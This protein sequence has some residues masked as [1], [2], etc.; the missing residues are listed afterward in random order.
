MDVPRNP[1]FLTKFT[2]QI[3][4]KINLGNERFYSNYNKKKPPSIPRRCGLFSLAAWAPSVPTGSSRWPTTVAILVPADHRP[5]HRRYLRRPVPPLGR[6]LFSLAASTTRRRPKLFS[7]AERDR[8]LR[9]RRHTR[10]AHLLATFGFLFTLAW[11]TCLK[12]SDNLYRRIRDSTA[13][14]VSR[15]RVFRVVERSVLWWLDSCLRDYREEKTI[16]FSRH[17]PGRPWLGRPGSR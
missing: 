9:Y 3:V 15:L 17:S 10:Q 12:P 8:T 6:A 14:A 13:V 7:L 11:A 16:N 5:R 4:G 2:R 1:G